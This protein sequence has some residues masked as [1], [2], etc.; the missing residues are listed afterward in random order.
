AEPHRS[1]FLDV[2]RSVSGRTWLERLDAAE[3]RA[4]GAIAQQTGLSEILSRIIAARGVAPAD[5]ERYLQPT[6]RD[7]MPDPSTL[8][9]MDEAAERLVM[10]IARAE[11]I[12]LFGD[13]DVDGAS[14]CALMTLYL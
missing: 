1:K 12:A 4:A 11:P 14:S 13:Y 3:G 6:I 7:L 9:A 5:A 2:E 10:A 8:T